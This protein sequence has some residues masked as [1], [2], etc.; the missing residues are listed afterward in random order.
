LRSF[1]SSMRS[2]QSGGSVSVEKATTAVIE[3][4]SL[5]RAAFL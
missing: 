2:C 1:I 3:S 4:R 5:R